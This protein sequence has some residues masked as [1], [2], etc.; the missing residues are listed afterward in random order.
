M[1]PHT[2]HRDAGPRARGLLRAL[3]SRNYRLFFAGQGI[4]LIGTWIQTIALSW[5]VYTLTHSPLLL[6]LVGFSA[7]IAT[8]ILVPF[9]GVVADRLNRHR[10][11]VATQSLFALQALVLGYLV[12]ADV[13]A[14]WHIVVLSALLGTINAFDMPTRQ[15]FVVEMIEHREDLPN[16]IALNSSMFNGARLVGPAIAGILIAVVGKGVCFLIN[17]GSYL[18]VL[19]ALL[20]MRVVP[21]GPRGERRHVWHEMREG[22]AFAFGFAPI[23]SI[24]LLLAVVSFAGMPYATLM[25]IF[26]AQ[27]LHGSASTLGFLSGATGVGALVG[28]IALASRKTVLG[29]GRWISL[30]CAG[31]GAALIGFAYSRWLP[32]SLLF[33][34]AA[35]LGMIMHMASSNTILQTIVDDTRRGRVMRFYTMAFIGMAP[36]GSLMGGAL[37]SR[38]G[39]PDTVALGGALCLVGAA[40]FA[41]RLPELRR[42]VRPIYRE[43]GIIPEVATGVLVATDEALRSERR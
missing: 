42:L 25:P 12:L 28:A 17:A 33:L 5:L 13:I 27:V 21:R 40:V 7:Q 6:G 22:F 2:S 18:A 3:Q 37:A 8:F 14:V 4:S 23:R 30:A 16:A 41:R 36:F 24:L 15:A 34:A 38:I 31:F 39:A 19:A 29:L 20:A 11:L 9:A 26:A 32:L 10:M 35:G 1:A 43:R